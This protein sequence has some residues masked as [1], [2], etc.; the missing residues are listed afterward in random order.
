[1]NRPFGRLS[2]QT[3]VV[4]AEKASIV[5]G[6]NSAD[7]LQAVTEWTRRQGL[8]GSQ[9]PYLGHPLSL[10]GIVIEAGASENAAI[11]ALLHDAIEDQV[12][13]IQTGVE[14]SLPGPQAGRVR[15]TRKVRHRS[16]AP[17]HTAPIRQRAI[18]R[19]HPE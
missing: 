19:Q 18:R 8:T 1:M 14:P 15:P 16:I 9:S 4:S 13:S 7:A 10:A 12:A 17:S 11:A 3:R 5:L 6:H 2:V